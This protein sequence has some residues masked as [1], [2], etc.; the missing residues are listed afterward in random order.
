[1]KCT[2]CGEEIQPNVD[3][4]PKCGAAVGSNGGVLDVIKWYGIGVSILFAL[5]SAWDLLLMILG[6][7]QILMG[8]YSIGY[9]I[10]SVVLKTVLLVGNLAISL[11]FLATG[12][13]F[14]KEKVISAFVLAASGVLIRFLYS[15]FYAILFKLMYGALKLKWDGIGGF[16]FA[17]ILTGVLFG[18]LFASGNMPFAGCSADTIKISALLIPSVIKEIFDDMK[19]AQKNKPV[20][21]K[22]TV[23]QP[24]QQA[25]PRP[26]Q[27]VNQQAGSNG[28]YASPVSGGIPLQTDRSL[29]MYIL[30]T[31]VTCGFYSLYF[32]YKMAADTNVACKDD[33][34][35]TAGLGM[36]ILLSMVTCGMYSIYWEYSLGNRLMANAPRYGLTF[37]E[38]GTSVLMWRLF[39]VVL[40]GIGPF[41]AMNIL[42]KNANAICD[43][44]NRANNLY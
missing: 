11:G 4:C 37:T 9:G 18:L 6:I 30:L 40:C 32:V 27:P 23:V 15:L 3:Y 36:Y 19:K 17:L 33:G 26:G 10:F 8:G 5:M 42:I 20:N 12:F 21:A 14:K 25:A 39:G 41:I 2:K 1:M 31:I 13:N 35:G 24:T 38:N 22:L 7:L 28:P 44:Y 34:A 29:A 43:A 16:W